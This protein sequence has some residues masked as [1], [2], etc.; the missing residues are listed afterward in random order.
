MSVELVLMSALTS[1][2]ECQRTLGKRSSARKRPTMPS[3]TELSASSRDIPNDDA[4]QLPG[5]AYQQSAELLPWSR[6]ATL[7][8]LHRHGIA[9][10]K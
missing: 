5:I 9:A 2:H 6:S 7:H 10:A 4:R 3:A 1:T 8:M